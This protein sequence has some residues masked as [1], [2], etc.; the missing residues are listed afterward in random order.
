VP[1]SIYNV[2]QSG[3]ERRRRSRKFGRNSGV[4]RLQ[5]SELDFAR[6]IPHKK[7]ALSPL[8]NE[9]DLLEIRALPALKPQQETCRREYPVITDRRLVVGY[10]GNRIRDYL[11]A[12]D[13]EL[14]AVGDITETDLA[15]KE[16]FAVLGPNCR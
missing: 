10:R 3:R 7:T 14:E 9:A 5:S 16:T 6:S 4:G 2:G 11:F 1:L 12:N 13:F 15:R 8:L